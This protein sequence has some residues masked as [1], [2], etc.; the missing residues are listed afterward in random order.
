MTHIASKRSSQ[1]LINF[2]INPPVM[3]PNHERLHPKVSQ[4]EAKELVQYFNFVDK[5][6]TLGWPPKA[7]KAGEN[8]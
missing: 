3:R 2:F 7:H 5:I 6:P 4:E 1:E 8:S